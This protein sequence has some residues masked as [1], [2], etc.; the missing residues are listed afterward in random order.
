MY[1]HN[2]M[3]L[4]MCMYY[5]YCSTL[6]F[7]VHSHSRSM[8]LE[9]LVV[10]CVQWPLSQQNGCYTSEYYQNNIIYESTAE[11][12]TDS[13]I[14][15]HIEMAYQR[16]AYNDYTKF[17]S[18]VSAILCGCSSMH[19]VW[20]TFKQSTLLKWIKSGHSEEY[21]VISDRTCHSDCSIAHYIH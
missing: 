20:A 10:G 7:L 19:H 14:Q 13:Y 17:H 21:P 6:F 18:R 3:F 16:V 9:A 8:L 1:L 2:I 11:T 5:S 15:Y 4:C 12:F